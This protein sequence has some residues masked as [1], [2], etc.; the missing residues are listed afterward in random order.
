MSIIENAVQFMVGIANDPSNGYDQANRWGP[1]YD[2]SSLVITSWQNAGVPVKTNGATYTGNMYNV[3]RALGFVDVTASCNLST[4]AGMQRGDVLLNHVN[5][6]A[7]Y[8]GNGQLVQASINEKGTVTGGQTGDQ[9]QLNGQRGE[10]NIRS[11]YNYPWDCVLRYTGESSGSETTNTVT[12]GRVS[13]TANL[14]ILKLGMTGSAVGVWQTI[15]CLAGYDTK[16]DESFG[17][18]TE[19]QTEAFERSKGITDDPNEVGPAAW[20]A[21]LEILSASKTF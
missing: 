1:D 16:V 18:N 15:L 13:V 10:I 9:K 7:V 4:G 17:S 2:C 19:E 11:Y 14:P 21:G 6:T 5:H 12:G 20:K 8:I 3:F